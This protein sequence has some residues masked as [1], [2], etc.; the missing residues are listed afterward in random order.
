MAVLMIL[1]IDLGTTYTVTAGIDATGRPVTLPNSL[2]DH[3][4]P[5]VVHFDSPDRVLVGVAAKNA[6]TVDPDNTVALIKRR[7]GTELDLFFH[8]VRHTPESVSALILRGA[9]G[10]ATGVRAVITVPAYFGIR[11]R[12]AT[13]QAAALAGIEVLELLS[14]PVAAALHYS[15]AVPDS[16][17]TT[18]VYDLGGGTFDTTVLKAG[19]HGVDVVA[20]DGDSHLGGADWDAR[21]ASYLLENF[22]RAVPDVDP[23]ED[24]TFLNEMTSL[25]EKVKRDL[26]RVASRKVALRCGGATASVEIDRTTIEAMGVDLV[27]RTLEI[28]RRVLASARDRG[29]LRVGAVILVGGSSRMPAIARALHAELGVEPRLVEPDLAVAYGA[30]IRAHQ[31]A[32]QSELRKAGGRLSAIAQG[33]TR[34]VVPRSFGVLVEDSHDPSGQG[35]L[36]VHTVHRNDPLPASATTRFSTIVDGQDRVRVQIYEQAGDLPSSDVAHNR[37][38]L[39]GELS[40]LPPLAAGSHVEVTLSVSAD[41]L[42]SVSAREPRSGVTLDLQSYVDGVVDGSAHVELA[43]SLAGVTVSQ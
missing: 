40:G 11:E 10:N 28:T 39:D 36:V 41:G 9:V 34:S 31:L 7:M 2:G 6:S 35:R 5:S 26:S 1:G 37:R 33:S 27:D 3:T 43:A 16:A 25:A 17:T 15:T 24:E 8:G 23:Y 21:I 29:V 12:E 32:G 14:E 30:A 22:A 13:F 38:V 20:T 19:D 42:L 4:T 18:L